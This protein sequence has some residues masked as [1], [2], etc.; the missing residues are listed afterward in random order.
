MRDIWQLTVIGDTVIG[1]HLP[2][3]Q[4]F[5]TATIEGRTHEVVQDDTVAGKEGNNN[6]SHV[7][8]RRP[9]DSDQNS[10]PGSRHLDLNIPLLTWR[11][12]MRLITPTDESLL[13]LIWTS[14]QVFSQFPIVMYTALQYAFALCWIS[15]QASPVSMVSTPPPY[16]FGTVG[17]GNMSLGVFI[18]CIIR[19]MYGGATDRV[20][21]VLARRNYGLRAGDA[22]SAWAAGLLCL[23]SPQPRYDDFF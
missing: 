23:G 13:H 6:L 2:S 4:F 5:Y 1:S 14:V 20:I 10:N 9:S 19:S 11:Q 7:P 21:K 17:V 3:R 16:N 8:S 15:A 18:G 12:R 22:A